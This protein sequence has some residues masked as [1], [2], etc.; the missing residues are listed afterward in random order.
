KLLK[1]KEGD[2]PDV[3]GDEYQDAIYELESLKLDVKQEMTYSP[4]VE[5]DLVVKTDPKAGRSV[6]E[7]STVTIFVSQGEE[8]IPFNDYVGRDFS[9]VKRILI[10]RGFDEENITVYEKNSDKSVGEIIAQIQPSP[11]SK[12]IPSEEQVIFE[13]SS[14]PKLVSLNN[15][16]GYSESEAKKYLEDRKLKMNKLEENSDSVPEGEVIR[17]NPEA[18]TELEEGATVD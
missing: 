15:L 1:P 10:D 6:K 2:V 5:E 12:V 7:G 9:Q 16:K 14:G 18:N 11:D 4:D 17:Q 3:V 8:P 13:V